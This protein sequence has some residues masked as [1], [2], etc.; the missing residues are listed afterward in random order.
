[1]NCKNNFLKTA[2]IIIGFAGAFVFSQNVVV[3]AGG[4]ELDPEISVPIDPPDYPKSSVIIGISF[5][6][7]SERVLA[8]GSDNWPLTWAANGHQY[9]TWGDGGGF[10]GS[11]KLGR[12]S[13]GVARIEGSKDDYQGFNIAGGADSPCPDPFTGKSEGILAI[14]NT[15]YLWRNGDASATSSFKFSRLYR[16]SDLGCSWTFTGVEFSKANGDFS[17]A[18]EG[19]FSPA[20]LQFSQGYA[21]ARDNYVYIYAPEIIDPGHWDL[22]KPGRITLMRVDKASINNKSAYSF[23]VGVDQNGA[24]FWTS[25]I[26]ARKP[27]WKT[28][29]GTHRMAVSYN[30]P[31][32]I[33][34]LTTM[35]VDRSGYISIYDAPEPWGPWTKAFEEKNEDRWGGKA[36]IFTFANKWLSSDGKDFVIVHT[37]DDR[38]A[39]LEG[40]FLLATD[41]QPT[42]PTTPPIPPVLPPADTRKPSAPANLTA[43]VTSSQILLSWE[44]SN[45]NF[46]AVFY[47]IL[48]CQSEGCTAFEQMGTSDKNSFADLNIVPNEFYRY[49]VR[50]RDGAGNAS[51]NS[52]AKSARTW[53]PVSTK[54]VQTQK[55]ETLARLNVRDVPTRSEGKILGT[56]AVGS[57]GTIIGG[58]FYANNQWWWHIDYDNGPDGWSSENYLAGFNE[59]T[60]SSSHYSPPL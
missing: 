7:P 13:I 58:P 37:K 8:P 59:S 25:D 24:A 32:K 52:H 19:F 49:R 48:R 2:L 54:F 53:P 3:P 26:S 36:V 6:D 45:D 1:M 33:Y 27:V 5:N 55:V 4:F 57:L 50:A 46:G 20:F 28:I 34:L 38:F 15:L 22:Q 39:S 60:L 44:H 10:E 12:A 40:T 29:N 31:L 16:S 18:D 47:E 43:T 11:D 30:A 42:P 41:T 56:Q 35:T 9:T 23:F 51:K 14:G 21:G 17:G